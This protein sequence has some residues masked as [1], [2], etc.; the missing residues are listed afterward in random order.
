MGISS[1][2]LTYWKR[3]LEKAINF[4]PEHLS[5]YL[6]SYETG[7][8]LF[9][10]AETGLVQPVSEEESCELFEATWT[11]L[12]SAGFT[13]YEVSNFARTTSF[14]SRH[15]MKYWT[16]MPYIG[17]GPGAHSFSHNQRRWNQIREA[18]TEGSGSWNL[19]IH[20]GYKR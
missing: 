16:F 9:D 4:Q 1:K 5:C 19:Y 18:G 17:L 13:Q 15:N 7:T 12:E 6:L 14:Y 2:T 11:V 10:K 3:D 8:P 20:T